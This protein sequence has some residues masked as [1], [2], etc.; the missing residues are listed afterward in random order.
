MPNEFHSDV[1]HTSSVSVVDQIKPN[2][3][4]LTLSG[5]GSIIGETACMY[6]HGMIK[7]CS[8]LNVS[9]KRVTSCKTFIKTLK[10]FSKTT[11]ITSRHPLRWECSLHFH[12]TDEILYVDI[13]VG[14]TYL[15]DAVFDFDHLRIS[16]NNMN[17]NVFSTKR[18]LSKQFTLV[19]PVK[20]LTTQLG[21][22]LMR[23]NFMIKLGWTM[24]YSVMGYDRAWLLSYNNVIP[25]KLGCDYNDHCS[26]CGSKIK[27]KDMVVR[28]HVSYI[29]IHYACYIA[30]FG[31]E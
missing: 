26:I 30:M 19:A 9:F 28:L 15:K 5:G 22:D 7:Q 13:T 3:M 17:N 14:N 29:K 1:S 2:I 6:Y 23:A 25:D 18:L 8:I 20:S 21:R 16:A 10:S 4:S 27:S 12:N 31:I 11:I 24:D